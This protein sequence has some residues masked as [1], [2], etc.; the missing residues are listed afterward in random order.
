MGKKRS[1]QQSSNGVVPGDSSESDGSQNQEKSLNSPRLCQHV[2]KSVDQNVS[3]KNLNLEDLDNNNFCKQ[4]CKQ[5][6]SLKG[7][8]IFVCLRCGDKSCSLE[9]SKVHND[10]PR[11]DSHAL[12]LK[13]S[14]MTV[15]CHGCESEID[16]STYKKLKACVNNVDNLYEKHLQGASSKNTPK[17][18]SIAEESSPV[19]NK[20]EA[21]PLLPS[22]TKSPSQGSSVRGLWNLGNTCF[23]NSVLQC[24]A[25]TPKLYETLKEMEIPKEVSIELKSGRTLEGK[26]EKWDSY[27]EVLADTLC[28]IKSGGST[29]SPQQLLNHLRKKVPQFRGSDQHDS[30]ELLRH[31]LDSVRCSDLK[32]YRRIMLN[33]LG[34]N[35]IDNM[36]KVDSEKTKELKQ[37]DREVTEKIMLVPDQVFRGFLVSRLECQECH[38]SSECVESFLDL[39]LPVTTEKPHPPSIRRKGCGSSPEEKGGSQMS[40]HQLKKER[41]MERKKNRKHHGPHNKK[42]SGQ[43]EA[44]PCIVEKDESDQ[45][46]DEGDVDSEESDKKTE[47]FVDSSR[48]E[49]MLCAD[50]PIPPGLPVQPKK[51]SPEFPTSSRSIPLTDEGVPDITTSL[52]KININDSSQPKFKIFVRDAATIAKENPSWLVHFLELSESKNH[53]ILHNSDHFS[54]VRDIIQEKLGNEEQVSSEVKSPSCEKSVDV[55]EESFESQATSESMVTDD[56]LGAVGIQS[57]VAEDSQDVVPEDTQGEVAEDSQEPLTA[58]VTSE[59]DEEFTY[60]TEKISESVNDEKNDQIEKAEEDKHSDDEV[61]VG[62][63]FDETSFSADSSGEC[64][65]QT[66]LSQFT[67]IE[68]MTGSNKVGCET[69]TARANK[70]KKDGKTVYTMSTKQLLIAEAPPVLILHIKRFQVQMSSFRKLSRHVAFPL[71]LDI[72]PFCKKETVKNSPKKLV[73]SLYGIVEHSGNFNGGHY[74]AY[75]KVESN[76][77]FCISDSYVHEVKESRVLQAQAYLLFYKMSL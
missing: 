48:R 10:A 42:D 14:N 46:A 63:L 64:S 67:G 32:R 35:G 34:L 65:V 3:R 47:D 45:E 61:M 74:V 4:C 39:S 18:E 69:C 53:L 26:L 24:L 23:F 40:K 73:Y 52:N 12:T 21:I 44:M 36:E 30:H 49:E 20:L 55:R 68:L 15:W 9:H 16:V 54:S 60:S 56:S 62:S 51:R 11:S 57:D 77:W 1:R 17:I 72:S 76:Q 66:C 25:Q 7:E 31:L 27:C 75:V 59:W 37:L 43:G 28:Q 6:Q 38:H 29:F 58:P 71:E 8:D 50:V 22:K 33:E 19:E 41:K 2:A 5:G 13:L 70:G